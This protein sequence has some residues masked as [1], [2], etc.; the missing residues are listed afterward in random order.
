MGKYLG[1]KR[2]ICQFSMGYI[3]TFFEGIALIPNNR[4][5][6]AGHHYR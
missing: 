6:I 3:R 5:F 2:R 4:T 1:V